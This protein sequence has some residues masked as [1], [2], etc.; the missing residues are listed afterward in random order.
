MLKLSAS[1]YVNSAREVLAADAQ[2]QGNTNV[3]SL[4]TGVDAAQA[5]GTSRFVQQQLP[6]L[7]DWVRAAKSYAVGATASESYPCSVS[8]SLL[9]TATDA[10]NNRR[11]DGGDAVTVVAND[12]REPN[13]DPM[14]GTFTITVNAISGDIDSDKYAV[15]LSVAFGNLKFTSVTGAATMAGTV[16]LIN[17]SFG[18]DGYKNSFSTDNYNIT[19]DLA[20]MAYSRVF[21][22]YA[23]SY[24]HT[25]TA[26]DYRDTLVIN[27]SLLSSHFNN[28]SV[29]IS[30][31]TPLVS[32]PGGLQSGQ[33]LLTGAAGGQVRVSADG[34]LAAL[35]EFDEN[36][37][38][39]YDTK[40]TQPW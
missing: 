3:S 23:S 33:L 26:P 2:L 17:E 31:P 21:T 13:A 10:N 22:N 12:C 34:A 20:G 7:A 11:L 24:A 30:T 8:G 32:V 6:R 28:Q 37:D 4:V 40:T 35:V 1:N 14:T 36:G 39:N 16:R 19:G 5:T 38:G 9:V 27:G 29:R 25:G 15:D 18:A